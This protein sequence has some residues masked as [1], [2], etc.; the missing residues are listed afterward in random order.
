MG[1]TLQKY[2]IISIIVSINCL[3]IYTF[4]IFNSVWYAYLCILALSS[5]L[6]AS[7]SILNIAFKICNPEKNNYR[8][9][10]KNYIY[11]VPCYNES[12][13][14]LRYS[15]N[16]LV[17]QRIVSGDKRMIVIICDGRV[18]G[19]GN[20]FSTDIILKDLLDI[21]G[22][23]FFYEYTTWTGEKNIIREYKSDYSHHGITLPVILIVKENNVGKRDSLVLIRRICYLYNTQEVPETD[24]DFMSRMALDLETIYTDKIDYIIGIDADTIFDYNCS[25]ELIQGIEQDEK[26]HGC[27][28][29]VDIYKGMNFLSPF[30]LY[31]YAE[32][33]YAQCLRRQAQANITN[34]VSCLSGCNQILRISKETC[35]EKILNVFNYCPKEDDNILTHIRSYASEDR[36]HVC[37]M[38]SMYPYVKTTQTLKALSYTV[39][40][41][42]VKVFLSQRRRWNLGAN[43]NDLLLIYLPGINIF[44][45]ILAIANVVTFTLTPFVFVATVYFIIT[46]ITNPTILMLYLSIILFIPLFY[47]FLIPICIR[48]LSCKDAIYY[49]LSYIMFFSFSGIIS[50]V[51]YTYA[52]M[53]MDIIKWGK[54]RSI[55][56][57]EINSNIDDNI[58]IA[59]D[60]FIY[61]YEFLTLTDETIKDENYLTVSPEV[62]PTPESTIYESY[63]HFIEDI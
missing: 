3:L 61:D 53:N 54:T 49:Y 5:T 18:K 7:S 52:I 8:I 58:N 41:T 37:N 17:E 46:I 1:I 29:Y 24:A 59:G 4:V 9:T 36:N 11:V 6:N 56:K 22:I 2:V 42:S 50:L 31:Q 40:P 10:P 51:S 35:G 47:S 63:V 57:E 27:V 26:I 32:Y 45:R 30:V 23:G 21:D 16:S 55:M 14:E 19:A 48:Y 28:G 25:Y 60:G 12:E 43:S 33:T 62:Q 39:V 13:L 38:L 34:K 15:L 20:D 44:E